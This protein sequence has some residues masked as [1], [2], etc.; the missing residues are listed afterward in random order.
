MEQIGVPANIGPWLDKNGHTWLG[1]GEIK[2]ISDI[3]D[4]DI[5][6]VK[7]STASSGYHAGII[8]KAENPNAISTVEGN[9]KMNGQYLPEAGDEITRSNRR[10]LKDFTDTSCTS[11]GVGRW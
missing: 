2:S 4:G 8:I 1:P 10:T 3:K 6:V 11:C 5:F 9:T 7:S